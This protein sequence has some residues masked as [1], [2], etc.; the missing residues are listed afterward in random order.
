MNFIKKIPSLMSLV[1]SIM[2]NDSCGVQIAFVGLNN[3]VWEVGSVL[4]QKQQQLGHLSASYVIL[5]SHVSL[6]ASHLY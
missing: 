4:K 1:A 2:F 3:K 5:N 6:L